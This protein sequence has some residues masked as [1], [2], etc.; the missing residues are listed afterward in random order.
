MELADFA[1]AVRGRRDFALNG[2][3]ARKAVEIIEAVYR[4]S[5]TGM[6]V[7]MPL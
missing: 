4:S 5:R 6:P 7:A 2:A 3:E 1:D